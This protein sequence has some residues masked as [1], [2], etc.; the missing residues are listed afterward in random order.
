MKLNIP[1]FATKRQHL[2]LIIALLLSIPFL[3]QLPRV[4]TVDNVDYFT[5]KD[6]PDTIFYDSLKKTFGDDEFFVIAFSRPD[7]FTPQILGSIA[8]ITKELEALPE[9]REVQ[10]LANVDYIHGAEDYFEVRPFLEK[11]PYDRDGLELLREQALENK[12]YTGNLIS[13]GGTTTAIVVFPDRHD[14]KD[15][16]FRSR[17]INKTK[18]VL[19]IY[20]DV[21]GPFHMAGWTVTNL[22]LSQYMESDVAV[23]VPVTYLFITLTVW[24]VFRNIRLTIAAIVR[25]AHSTTCVSASEPKSPN[26]RDP[27]SITCERSWV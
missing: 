18:S 7:L 1:G 23:F 21:M 20:Q 16:N 11:I 2:S 24:L 9:V 5:I 22:S 10:S 27:G 3:A 19:E 15:G 25:L 4:Q 17:L 6:D 26:M 8:D 13:S 12:L 14:S